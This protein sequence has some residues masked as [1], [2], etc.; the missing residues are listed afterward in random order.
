MKITTEVCCPICNCNRLSVFDDRRLECVKCGHKQ[1]ITDVL[2]RYLSESNFK[3][4][5]SEFVLENVHGLW[6]L[7]IQDGIVID[8]QQLQPKS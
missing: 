3:G 1:K 2:P 4:I 6:K 8:T 7:T 5:A